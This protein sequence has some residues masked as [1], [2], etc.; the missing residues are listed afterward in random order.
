MYATK[1]IGVA[2]ATPIICHAI[3]IV[4][5]SLK[6]TSIFS[7]LWTVMK[8]TKLPHSPSS[9]SVRKF[10]CLRSSLEKLFSKLFLAVRHSICSMDVEFI[11]DVT[12]WTEEKIM[13]VVKKDKN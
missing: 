1:K 8:S 13:K 7:L 12:K 5:P 4:V 2:E 10:S 11:K 9:N 6:V 3:R